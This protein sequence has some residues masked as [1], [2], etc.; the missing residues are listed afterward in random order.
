MKR[1]GKV[2]IKTALFFAGATVLTGLFFAAG[3]DLYAW[4]KGKAA[5]P[6]GVLPPAA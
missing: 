3:Y 2:T 6:S 1:A 5:K 4:L